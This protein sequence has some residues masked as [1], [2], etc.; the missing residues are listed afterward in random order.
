MSKASVL[1]IPFAVAV[2]IALAVIPQSSF[3]QH[4]SH[5]GGFHGGGFASHNGGGFGGFHNRGG[6]G[7]FHNGGGFSRFH[8]GGGFGEFHNGP[9]FGGFAGRG[10]PGFRG[11]FYRG[12]RGHDGYGYGL[13]FGFFADW[14]VYPYF[15]GYAPWWVAPYPYYYP[16]EYCVPYD[17]YQDPDYDYPRNGRCLPD[18][19]HEDQCNDSSPGNSEPKRESAPDQPSN[20]D[21]SPD[22]NYLTRNS[23]EDDRSSLHTVARPTAVA[24]SFQVAH[25]TRPQL[26]SSNIRPAVANA[27]QAL[28]AMPPDARQRQ[29]ESGRYANFS[30]EERELL[31]NASQPHVW[32]GE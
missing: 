2:S 12:F 10:F 3:A 30:A 23:A 16:Y 26:P 17:R 24:T 28:R 7:G 4:S 31:N 8:N 21:S 6:F 18:Y 19:R 22:R 27:I 1:R 14:G 32:N 9:G 15:Y 25:S 11:P 5:G 20:T 13:T 29:L